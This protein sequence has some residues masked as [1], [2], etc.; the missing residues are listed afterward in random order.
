MKYCFLLFTLCIVGNVCFAQSSFIELQ[1]RSIGFSSNNS[2]GLTE[3]NN[4]TFNIQ[5]FKYG[6]NYTYKTQ[7]N[8]IF[9][10]FSDLEYEFRQTENMDGTDTTSSNSISFDNT[11]E[12]RIGVGFGKEF[13]LF[14]SKVSVRVVNKLLYG[15]RRSQTYG[16]RGYYRF[17]TTT[18]SILRSSYSKTP[19]TNT[20]TYQL[21]PAIFINKKWFSFGIA[22]GLNLEYR[23]VNDSRLR[24]QERLDL[25]S[26]VGSLKQITESETQELS[27]GVALS[28]HLDVILR[29]RLYTK[30][31][32]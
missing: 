23:H 13:P 12:T 16:T 32:E 30:S 24:Y 28:Q 18:Y 1:G 2:E 27:S 3:I 10:V 5:Q 25:N 26:S 8:R 14:D 6:L 7:T 20:I 11:R 4:Q 22:Y 31:K 9:G 21:N 17:G 15:F 19:N 29:F